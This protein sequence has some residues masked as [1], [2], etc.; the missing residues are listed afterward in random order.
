MG[1]VSVAGIEKPTLEQSAGALAMRVLEYVAPPPR[2]KSNPMLDCDVE[3]QRMA[4]DVLIS[5]QSNQ[6][7]ET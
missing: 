1:N 2:S 4:N 7:T 6:K 5:L 3:L